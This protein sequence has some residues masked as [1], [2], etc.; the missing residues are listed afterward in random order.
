M[1][2]INKGF[3]V[4][5][6][7][8]EGAGKST[9]IKIMKKYL[10]NKGWPIITTREPGGTFIGDQLRDILLDIDNKEIDCK[11]EALLYAASRA[12]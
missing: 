7:G 2:L 9:Q 1:N 12:Q 10:G 4:T 6:E 11:V 5:F 8:I 3:F